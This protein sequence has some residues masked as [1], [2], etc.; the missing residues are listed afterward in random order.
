MQAPK[1]EKFLADSMTGAIVAL[2]SSY[3]LSRHYGAYGM[4]VG[5]L[6]VSTLVGLVLGTA[7]LPTYRRIWHAD[8]QTLITNAVP[9]Y[10]ESGP[11]RRIV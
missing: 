6:I 8:G 5:Y 11:P 10:D 7:T 2:I 1:Q 9:T 3:A 4:V